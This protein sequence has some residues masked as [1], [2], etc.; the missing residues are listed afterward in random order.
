[1]WISFPENI[2]H[3][4]CAKN[5]SIQILHKR[6]RQ[7]EL[8]AFCSESCQSVIKLQ[9]YYANTV[10]LHIFIL[11][12]AVALCTGASLFFSFFYFTWESQQLAMYLKFMLL[13]FLCHEFLFYGK[14]ETV[15]IHM[16]S[17]QRNQNQSDFKTELISMW[18][19]FKRRECK[20]TIENI[21]FLLE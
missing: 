17:V 16:C 9:H 2:I 11:N 1:M 6:D 5:K 15:F 7:C 14:T 20:K 18:N 3:L 4:Y 19:T 10:N 21:Q 8:C 13:Y 12:K